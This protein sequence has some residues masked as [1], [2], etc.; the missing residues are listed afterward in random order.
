MTVI[1][2]DACL[3]CSDYPEPE[4]EMIEIPIINELKNVHTEVSSLY[5]LICE[6][7]IKTNEIIKSGNLSSEELCDFGFL[8][9]EIENILDELRKEVKARKEVCGQILSYRLTKESLN[10]STKELKVSGEFAT[11]TPEMKM[12][13]ALPEKNSEEYKKVL[14]WFIRL[15]L[16]KFEITLSSTNFKMRSLYLDKVLEDIIKELTDEFIKEAIFKL[17]WKQ[18]TELCTKLIQEG[19]SIPEGF[20][21]QYP[22]YFITYRKKNLNGKK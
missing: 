6:F 9:R 2:D 12:E 21:K 22:K 19:K 13:V 18:V 8:C 20:G 10:D 15:L 5:N 17:D 7:F 3:D 11:G 14:E 4:P 16:H 1:N